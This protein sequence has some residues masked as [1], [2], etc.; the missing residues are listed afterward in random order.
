MEF[1]RI[2]SHITNLQLEFVVAHNHVQH[3]KFQ[4]CRSISNLLLVI[5]ASGNIVIYGM[6]LLRKPKMNEV[7]EMRN[8]SE[9]SV[10]PCVELAIEPGL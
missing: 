10:A 8:L 2:A 6:V 7:I 3:L 1:I 9:P 5:S 4:I